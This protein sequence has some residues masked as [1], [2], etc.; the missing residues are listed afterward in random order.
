MDSA[1]AVFT[2][3]A[4]SIET[5]PSSVYIPNDGYNSGELACGGTYTKEQD[6]IAIRNW[7]GRCGDAVAIYVPSTGHLAISKIR[8]AGPY[9]TM[10]AAGRWQVCTNRKPPKGFRWRSITDLSYALWKRLGRPRFLTKV[11]LYYI[12]PWVARYVKGI[13]RHTD[14][15]RKRRRAVPEL[16]VR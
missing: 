1:L 12:D 3:F 10:D 4:T 9:G 7:K 11:Q 6:H 13:I 2:L 15:A 5:G 14:E 8:D 16:A